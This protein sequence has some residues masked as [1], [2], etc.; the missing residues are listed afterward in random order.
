MGNVSVAQKAILHGNKNDC[1]GP[2]D[3]ECQAE[4]HQVPYKTSG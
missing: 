2:F 4:G 1:E 3:V